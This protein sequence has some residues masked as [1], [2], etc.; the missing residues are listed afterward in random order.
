MVIPDYLQ[1]YW[2]RDLRTV[3][4]TSTGTINLLHLMA[5]KLG[6]VS[7]ELIGGWTLLADSVIGN[8]PNIHIVGPRDVLLCTLL[9][10]M[11]PR[12]PLMAL[13]RTLFAF[14]GRHK[15]E[16]Q[17]YSRLRLWLSMIRS[18]GYDLEE[19]GRREMELLADDNLNLERY[20]AV[21]RRNKAT[22]QWSY[23][24]AQLRGYEY[25]SEPEDWKILLSFPENS[26]AAD[27]WRLI[28]EGPRV[29]PGTWIEES[30]EEE[31]YTLAQLNSLRQDAS[32]RSWEASIKSLKR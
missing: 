16:I 15:E 17:I 2:S 20:V 5:K 3:C 19:Y 4:A 8:T 26:Y 31:G 29:M 28:D 25:G 22:G 27:F 24:S 6:L 12:T 18:N 9:D 7:E 1:P 21:S 30:D 32:L 14:W 11:A 23:H 10:E 13:I